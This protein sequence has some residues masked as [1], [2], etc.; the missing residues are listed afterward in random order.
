MR[1]LLRGGY[2]H[3]P[4]D[5]HATALCIEDGAIVWTGDDDASAHFEEGADRVVD[6]AGRLV[7]PAFVDAHAHLAQT[8]FAAAGVDLA[9]PT[10]HDALD[11]L[12]AHAHGTSD[13]VILGSGWDDTVWPEGR[14]FTREEVDRATGGRPAYLARV[15]EHSAVV[16]SAFLDACPDVV[17]AEGY[18]VSG[19]VERDAHHAAREGLFRLL[20]PSAREDAIQRALRLAASQGIGMVHELGAPHICPPEDLLVARSLSGA[21]GLPEVV[22]YWGE[23]GAVDTA[24]EL[25]AVGLAGDLC[26]DGSLG[27]WTSALRAPYA[28]HPH[29]P[30]H[31][32]HLYVDAEQVTAHVLACT[33][34]GLQAGFHVIGDRAVDEVVAG[35]AKAAETLGDGA[36]VRGRHR[37]EHLEMV[38]PE[39]LE[40]LGRL[41]ITASQQPVFDALWG[42]DSGMYAQRLGRERAAGMNAFASLNR[43]GVAL[44]FGSDTPVTPLGPWA[45]V[46]A[47]AW[48][49]TEPERVTVR[50]AFNAHTRGGWRAAAR[51]EGGV[52]ALGAPASIAVWDVPSDLVV[53]TP[54]ARVAAWSTDP[55]AGVPHLPDL[56]PD[57]DLPTCVMTLVAGEVAY[58]REGALT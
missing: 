35:F 46:R 39:H 17:H 12:A 18:D 31:E 14:A 45:A 27:S 42:G 44:A 40:T 38:A 43:A 52:I 26:M 32:G 19:R 54:D 1:T 49:Q 15:D 23:L 20:P 34:A 41:G 57:L 21:G 10:L 3:T 28:D 25:G 55:R 30:A 7:T 9:T 51:D 58:E 4:A 24:R 37:L 6:L 33:E 13:P 53:Q 16:S 11:A 2:V 8:G 48:H 56:H 36:V 50:A 22:G 5:P 47:A 29:D